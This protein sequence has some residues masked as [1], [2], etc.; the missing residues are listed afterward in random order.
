MRSKEVECV[1]SKEI[2]CV[3]KAWARD[4]KD[5]DNAI[6]DDDDGGDDNGD[7]DG[8]GG[9]DGGDDGDGGASLIIV[10]WLT[11]VRT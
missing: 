8:D 9:Y 11:Y 6:N 1:R 5:V 10:G 2:H 3:I 7:D 4:D